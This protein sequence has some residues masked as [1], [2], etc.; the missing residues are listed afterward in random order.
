MIAHICITV[1]PAPRSAGL[2]SATRQ[3]GGADAQR[4]ARNDPNGPFC[5]IAQVQPWGH[6]RA[7]SCALVARDDRG[8]ALAPPAEAIVEADFDDLDVLIDAEG[9]GEGGRR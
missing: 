3:R 7:A 8:F 4:A 2:A 6:P 1:W 5:L 9:S